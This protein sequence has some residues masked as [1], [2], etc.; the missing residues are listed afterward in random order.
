LAKSA[1]HQK[2]D[3]AVPQ[4]KLGETLT[5]LHQVWAL[6]LIAV[7]FS[8]FMDEYHFPGNREE[9]LETEAIL[10]NV[11]RVFFFGLMFVGF[12]IDLVQ[13]RKDRQKAFLFLVLSLLL[14]GFSSWISALQCNILLQL[15]NISPAETVAFI[16]ST[17]LTTGST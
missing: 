6:F 4:E 3:Y 12:L 14:G 15:F 9:P 16:L 13:M 11:Q 10:W 8:G 2:S 1:F 17:P 5:L 7:Y